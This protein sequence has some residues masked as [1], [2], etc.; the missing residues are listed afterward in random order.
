MTN[1][2]K[3]LAELEQKGN[4]DIDPKVIQEIKQLLNKNIEV[5]IFSIGPTNLFLQEK[6]SEQIKGLT[7]KYANL[8]LSSHKSMEETTENQQNQEQ[9]QNGETALEAPP[10]EEKKPL[11]DQA[12]VL[13]ERVVEDLTEDKQKDLKKMVDNMVGVI[14]SLKLSGDLNMTENR[15]LTDLHHHI[16][17]ENSEEFHEINTV[18]L[19]I[20]SK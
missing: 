19:N 14:L 20:C 5:K 18:L 15:Y 8:E 10:Q 3:A 6:I 12:R 17:E 9:Q 16:F 7:D 2:L 13:K 1:P 4:E 11:S